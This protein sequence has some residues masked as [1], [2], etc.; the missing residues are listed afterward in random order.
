MAELTMGG[1][2][3]H[4]LALN[5]WQ[6]VG[7]PPRPTDAAGLRQADLCLASLEDLE[8]P[9]ERVRALGGEVEEHRHGAAVTDPSG[10]RVYLAVPRSR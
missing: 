8:G 5:I 2:F 4:R 3:F 9:L 7:A 6:G 10:N 1:S